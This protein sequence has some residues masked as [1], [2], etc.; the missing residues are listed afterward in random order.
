MEL[1]INTYDTALTKI[2]SKTQ[3]QLKT[4][5][6][7]LKNPKVIYNFFTKE[8]SIIFTLNMKNYQAIVS[9]SLTLITNGAPSPTGLKDSTSLPPREKGRVSGDHP[10]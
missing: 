8:K 3:G 9:L 7:C 6:N 4:L 2:N 10:F 5:E 1:Q